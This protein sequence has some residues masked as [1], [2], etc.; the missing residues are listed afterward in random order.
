MLSLPSHS[1]ARLLPLP[2]PSDG[3]QSVSGKRQGLGSISFTVTAS[4]LVTV[5]VTASESV[6]APVTALVMTRS[7]TRSCELIFEVLML[8][9]AQYTFTLSRKQI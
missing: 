7:F 4:E 9:L 5:P 3:V 1:L 6:T 2:L 8:F